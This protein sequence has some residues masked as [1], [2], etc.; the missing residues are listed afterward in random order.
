MLATL[1]LSVLLQT[2]TIVPT[3]VV[4]P[5]PVYMRRDTTQNYIVIHYDDGIEPKSTL[6]WLR[7]KHLAYHYFI[8]RNGIIYKLVDP[9][10]QASHAGW[11]MWDGHIGMN[12]YSIGIALQNDSEQDYTESQYQSLLWLIDVLEKRFPDIT[13]DRIVGHDDVA[14]PR[15]R[16]QDP[17]EYFDWLRIKLKR[18]INVRTVPT[19]AP[20]RDTSRDPIPLRVIFPIHDVVQLPSSVEAPIHRRP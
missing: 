20:Y 14:W 4:K 12:R 2:V 19:L 6:R 18:V 10:Y 5:F 13:V 1:Y 7:R 11:S 16:K 3:V 8:L 17:G 9:K 15:G